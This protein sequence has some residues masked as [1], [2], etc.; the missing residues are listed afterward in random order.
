MSHARVDT[1]TVLPRHRRLGLLLLVVPIASVIACGGT[2]T[3]APPPTPPP[4]AP[5]APTTVGSMPEQV[6]EQGRS[7]TVDA[8]GYF[9]DPDGGALTY[10]AESSLGTVVSAE[11]SGS[12]VTVSAI[13]PGTATV[14][15]TATDPDDL[16]A[17]QRFGVVV[18]GTV[19]DGFDSDASL[20]D[21]E[22]GNADLAV[23][24]GAVNLTNRTDGL[25]GIAE[26]RQMPSLNDWTIQARMGRTTRRASPG[27]VSLT[28]H[29]RFTAVR[30]VLRTL[31]DEDGDRDRRTDGTASTTSRNYEF[32]VFDGNAGEWVLV[33]N[34]S[35]GSE[36]VVE[37]PGAFTEIALGHEGGDFVAY[38]G[39]DGAAELFR[40]D[41][42]TTSLEGV[43]LGEIVSDVTGFWLVNQG[44]VGLTAQHD[45]ARVTGTGSGAAPSDGA[46]IAEAPDAATRSVSVAGPDAD[47]AA[48]VALYEATDGP[49]WVNSENWLTD[50]PLGEWYGVDA[51]DEGRV[52]SI[53]LRG[54]WDHS[55]G[56]PVS[57]G[58]SGPIPPELGNLAS[59][60][61]LVLQ[62]NGLSGP[63]PPS[64]GRLANLTVLD[65]SYNEF[66]GSIPSELGNLLKLKTLHIW[67]SNL[68]G[69]IPP[70]LGGLSE[71]EKLALGYSALSGSI[72]PE[73]GDLTNL[74]TL[75]L[76]LNE[77]TGEIP[78]ELGGLA[79]L[80]SLFL[81]R[82]PGLEGRLPATFPTGLT[83]LDTLR[84][85]DTG[86]CVP[87]SEEFQSFLGGLLHWTGASCAASAVAVP[88]YERTEPSHPTGRT[89]HYRGRRRPGH[90]PVPPYSLPTVR[91]TDPGD[92][93]GGCAR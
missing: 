69:S 51:D 8:A 92:P 55:R 88:S 10:A 93:L 19:A 74:R 50:A 89:Q 18:S 14:A 28:R 22:G 81:D 56:R 80:G 38:A 29:G 9:R 57:H 30:L 41:L 68:S 44:A 27:V 61:V 17:T 62:M 11:T 67:G 71:L 65:V 90:G 79:N 24:D 39:E 36:S 84:L 42:A 86:V 54:W 48:L 72:P 63:I 15:V 1:R 2:E 85:H 32:A 33:T 4:P 35:G 70:E 83:S 76:D 16:S 91:A 49:N 59:L 12:A 45:W 37:E 6:I 23:A 58:L 7:V 66:S 3:T 34:L 77:L 40:F 20:N 47:R 13:G 87:Q 26:R 60:T 46:G 64:L 73:L 31:D 82:N 43:A 5:V 25:L 53:V 78:P 21:W 75:W 52:V